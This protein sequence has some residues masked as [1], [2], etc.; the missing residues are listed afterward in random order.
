[1]DVVED[2]K[3]LSFQVIGMAG[4]SIDFGAISGAG[5]ETLKNINLIFE[6]INNRLTLKSNRFTS[7]TL[8]TQARVQ[9]V[10]RVLEIIENKMKDIESG[11]VR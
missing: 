1:V 7:K 4:Y 8:V 9:L 2:M 6:E 5:D 3:R 10:G 11:K